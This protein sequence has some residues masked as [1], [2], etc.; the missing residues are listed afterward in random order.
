MESTRPRCPSLR[1]LRGFV[2][3]TL[4]VCLVC[5]FLD[6][7]CMLPHGSSHIGE[8]TEDLCLPASAVRKTYHK[9][10]SSWK[11][12]TN[13]TNL[14]G[15]L[16]PRQPAEPTLSPDCRLA[17]ASVA[18]RAGARIA[19][20]QQGSAAMHVILDLRDLWVY[21]SWDPFTLE[22]LMKQKRGKM[23]ATASDDEVCRALVQSSTRANRDFD[24]AA[25]ARQRFGYVEETLSIYLGLGCI[26]VALYLLLEQVFALRSGQSR[27]E[28]TSRCC[29]YSAPPAR[30][31][32]F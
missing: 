12:K 22:G 15:S 11:D 31:K 16:P 23:P 10:L 27:K 4:A 24:A 7:T 13:A 5:C 20:R 3:V 25:R 30:L 26:I 2:G 32:D 9:R 8:G 21:K 28:G 18:E 17:E 29:G 6:A 19:G 1:S 14:R